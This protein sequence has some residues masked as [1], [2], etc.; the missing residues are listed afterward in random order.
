MVQLFDT[1][2]AK[3]HFFRHH[4][5]NSTAIQ[6]INTLHAALR[7][8]NKIREF[9]NLTTFNDCNGSLVFEEFYLF[10]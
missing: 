1:T 5:R 8:Q 7:N 10:E 3:C 6:Q 2:I 4:T 9:L